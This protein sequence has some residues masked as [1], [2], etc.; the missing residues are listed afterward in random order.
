MCL[1]ATAST[2]TE[3]SPEVLELLLG[4][5]SQLWPKCSRPSFA[6]LQLI[7]EIGFSCGGPIE[8]KRFGFRWLFCFGDGGAL[9]RHHIRTFRLE[10]TPHCGTTMEASS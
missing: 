7:L 2:T 3:V 4:L 6:P 5:M 1:R 10:A 8:G 9:A